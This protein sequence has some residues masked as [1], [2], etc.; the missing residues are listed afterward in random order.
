MR[1]FDNSPDSFHEELQ[2]YFP[3]WYSR[4]KEMDAI[5]EVSGDF[6]D[7]LKADVQ[8]AL[9]RV[10]LATCDAPTITY[11]QKWAGAS[12][13]TGMSD[14]VL[15][16]I[17]NLQIAGFGHCSRSR[18]IKLLHDLLGTECEVDFVPLN[19]E[20]GNWGLEISVDVG[21]SANWY[22]RDIE[23]ILKRII[24]AHLYR[25]TR[26]HLDFGGDSDVYFGIALHSV[27]TYM[28]SVDAPDVELEL[29]WFGDE[30]ENLLLDEN[31]L[32][33]FE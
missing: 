9:T 1:V 23:T 11:I 2:S 24:P 28:S 8:A 22:P 19:D 27:S 18:I 29:N 4:V 16:V 3:S 33:L 6:L 7:E 32:V 14:A 30:N 5:W 25:R 26:H 17:F 31:G 20:A 15:R 13:D 21:N 10:S 12:F